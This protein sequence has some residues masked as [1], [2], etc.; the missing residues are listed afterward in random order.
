M[1]QTNRSGL[2]NSQTGYSKNS[3]PLH[4]S[5]LPFPTHF[6]P[7]KSLT[8]LDTRPNLSFTNNSQTKNSS[9]LAPFYRSSS[10]QGI[11]FEKSSKTLQSLIEPNF[12]TLKKTEFFS[13][14]NSSNYWDSFAKKESLFG[15]DFYEFKKDMGWKEKTKIKLRVKMDNFL[16]KNQRKIKI[17]KNTVIGIISFLFLF[18]FCIGLLTLNT[19]LR[20]K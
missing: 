18:V 13:S 20:K 14:Q 16:R 5:C 11:P 15:E 8:S 19:W 17:A 1:S 12:S 4:S 9:F 3:R 7:S 6:S 2:F 10:T